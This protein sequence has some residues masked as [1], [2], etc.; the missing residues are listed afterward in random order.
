MCGSLVASIVVCLCTLF[1]LTGRTAHMNCGSPD[2]VVSE[3]CSCLLQTEEQR[4]NQRVLH[5]RD[6]R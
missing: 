1:S 2:V 5:M 6:F 4:L 3:L